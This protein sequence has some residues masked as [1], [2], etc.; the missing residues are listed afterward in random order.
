MESSS[1]T[2]GQADVLDPRVVQGRSFMKENKFEDAIALFASFLQS[3]ISEFGQISPQAALGFYEYGNVLLTNQEENPADGLIGNG[4]KGDGDVE[5]DVVG[6]DD[7]EVG[8]EEAAD[9]VSGDNAGATNDEA[10][11]ELAEADNLEDLQL[12]WENLDT[13]RH[14]LEQLNE[15]HNEHLLSDVYIRLGDLLRIEEQPRAAADEYLKALTI[16]LRTCPPH[17]RMLCDAHFSLAMAYV[18]LSSEKFA[19]GEALESKRLAL[20]HY[21]KAREVLQQEVAVKAGT[22]KV[23]EAQELVD[24]LTETIEALQADLQSGGTSSS[25]TQGQIVTTIGFGSKQDRKAAEAA[26]TSEPA[27]AT[28]QPKKKRKTED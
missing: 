23:E 26:A 19:T 5:D 3:Q 14:I 7:D 18:D 4:D 20:E 10:K 6:E 21:L 25:S 11:D 2:G 13:A 8:E 16:R 27:V 15:T 28:L 17:D 1:L 22:E 24:E 9:G 12:A